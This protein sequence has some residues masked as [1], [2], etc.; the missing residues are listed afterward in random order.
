MS[1]FPDPRRVVTGHDENG[2]AII[3]KDSLIPTEPTGVDCSFA[4]LW[5]THQFPASNNGWEDPIVHKTK[6]LANADGV[7]VRVVDFKPNTNTASSLSLE[8]P[9][10][11]NELSRSSI[12]HCRLILESSW[13]AR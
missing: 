8:L 12:V 11:T 10:V 6:S 1:F 4:V 5:E 2:N 13:R 3:V 7:I 9:L